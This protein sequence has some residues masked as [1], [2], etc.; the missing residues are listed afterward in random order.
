MTDSTTSSAPP[1]TLS[2]K[3]TP[4]EVR[5][6]HAVVGHSL[7]TLKGIS[8][9]S[10][11][12]VI[13]AHVSELLD[14]RDKIA[15]LNHERE[16]GMSRPHSDK[17]FIHAGLS[18][19]AHAALYAYVEFLGGGKVRPGSIGEYLSELILAA[20]EAGGATLE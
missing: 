20:Y 12:A 11:K 13:F 19:E 15:A 2:L 6:L 3:L 16:T 18:P 8:T 1:T 5:I 14:L 7:G 17:V 9:T 10:Q 4:E